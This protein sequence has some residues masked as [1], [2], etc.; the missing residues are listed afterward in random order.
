MTP[1]REIPEDIGEVD[2]DDPAE[3]VETLPPMEQLGDD[4]GTDPDDGPA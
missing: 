4:E 1:E 2:P 3:D